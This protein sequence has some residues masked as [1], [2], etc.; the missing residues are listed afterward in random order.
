MV[1]RTRIFVTLYYNTRIVVY[2]YVLIHF[3]KAGIFSLA[4]LLLSDYNV[5][6]FDFEINAV[7]WIH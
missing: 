7:C 5:A 6:A 3:Y 4:F 2:R 1:A